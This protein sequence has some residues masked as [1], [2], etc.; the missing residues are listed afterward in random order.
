[1][2]GRFTLRTPAS[3]VA[4]A[5]GLA[6]L[7][8]FQPRYNIA[9]RQAVAAV[10]IAQNDGRELAFLKWGLVPS[11]AD[12]PSIGYKM[13]NA[14]SE[15]AATK[16]SFRRA[17]KSRRCLIV[18]DG[19]YE[20]Q[21]TGSKKQ[22]FYIRLADGA[23]IG[24]AGLWEH[25][26]RDGQE[27]ESCTILTTDANELMAPIHNRMPVI[28]GR[29]D[30]GVWLDPAVQEVERL[31]PLLRPFLSGEMTAYPVST[32]VNNPKNDVEECVEA[33]Q[34]RLEPRRLERTG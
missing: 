34:K 15:T 22:P 26:K 6:D 12:E 32:V 27:I 13:I 9:P 5:F 31:Q 14:R 1:M 23:P 21:K 24:F 7:F 20:W 10:R 29:D 8:D 33:L 4:E 30:Y 3:H 2:C 18:A 25:W 28:V 16:P 11:W 19:F 17:F